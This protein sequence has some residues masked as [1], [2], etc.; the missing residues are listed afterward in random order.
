M[1]SDHLEPIGPWPR[2]ERTGEVHKTTPTEV[3][4][5]VVHDDGDLLVLSKDGVLPCHPSKDGPYSCLCGAVREVFGLDAAHLVFRLD[6][7]TSGLVVFAKTER[8][9]RRLQKA[10]EQH[11]YSKRYLALLEGELAAA[12]CVDQPLGRDWGSRVSVKSTVVEAGAGQSAVSRFVPLRVGAGKTLAG[13]TTETGRKHQI[14]AHAQWLGHSLVGDKI[15]G[16]DSNLFLRFIDSG[17]TPDLANA[18]TLPRQALHCASIDLEPAGLP[19]RFVS[20]WPPDLAQYCQEQ[21][22]WAE[23]GRHEAGD[24]VGR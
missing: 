1:S 3:R 18:L 14:R 10:A 24:W 20:P 7:E 15:Y 17:W 23:G 11:R 13:V 6:R 9:A 19:Y 12:A 8:M 5:W 21:L 22:G 4:S 2:L 16:P